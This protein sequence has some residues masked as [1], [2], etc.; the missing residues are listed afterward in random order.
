MFIKREQGYDSKS[1]AL[2]SNGNPYT[3]VV[4]IIMMINL[5]Q[6]YCHYLDCQIK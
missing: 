6:I 2:S 5:S 3:D 4:I 1:D